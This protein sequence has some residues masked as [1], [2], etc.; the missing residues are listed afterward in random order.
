[1]LCVERETHHAGTGQEARQIQ[2]API[3]NSHCLGVFIGGFGDASM[4]HIATLNHIGE[5]LADILG[6]V[7]NVISQT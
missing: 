1:M 5:V 7:A 3:R 4:T 6:T 2:Q